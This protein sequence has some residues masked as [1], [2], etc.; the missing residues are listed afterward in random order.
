[1]SSIFATN[2]IAVIDM[3]W[4]KVSAVDVFALFNS[5]VPRN[6]KLLRVAIYPSKYGS[7]RINRE[8]YTKLSSTRMLSPQNTLVTLNAT[9]NKNAKKNSKLST[10]GHWT[11]KI[12][13]L[14][15]F[16]LIAEFDSKETANIVYLACNGFEIEHSANVLDL[17]FVSENENFSHR[18]ASES[19]TELPFCYQRHSPKI[20]TNYTSKR[21]L[22]RSQ[23]KE[24]SKFSTVHS[25]TSESDNDSI[26]LSYSNSVVDRKHKFQKEFSVTNQEKINMKK[27]ETIRCVCEHTNL[28][29]VPK[30]IRDK[31]TCK[32]RNKENLKIAAKKEIT[33]KDN[34]KKNRTLASYYAEESK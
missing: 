33:E 30:K 29:P 1:M 22:K 24:L 27:V 5:F 16:Y 13:K 28:R 2:R 31:Y 9:R 18:K 6:G 8:Q 15:W 7:L 32:E 17:R 34:K 10:H 23:G 4:T 20:L 12:S 21:I 26:G 19:A 3:E 11:Y 25:I 14:K